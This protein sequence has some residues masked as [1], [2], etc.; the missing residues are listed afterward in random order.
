MSWFRISTGVMAAVAT[1]CATAHAQVMLEWTSN[2]PGSGDAISADESGF[3]YVS[4]GPDLVKLDLAG[5]VVWQRELDP[6]GGGR[7]IS[8][9]HTRD[10]L[11]NIIVTGGSSADSDAFLTLKY[12]SHGNKLWETKT[13]QGIGAFRV[14]TDAI[15]NAYVLGRTPSNLPD[16]VLAKYDPNGAEL[17][18]DVFSPGIINRPHHLAVS[19]N[20]EVAV[21]G[22]SNRVGTANDIMT[23]LYETD[24][25]IR[26]WRSHTSSISGGGLDS[27]NSVAF[28]PN[29]EVYVGGHSENNPSD[30]D[31]TLIKYDAAGNEIWLREY[32]SPSG[33]YDF[34]NRVAVD[35]TGNIF[36]V[37]GSERDIVAIKYDADGTQLWRQQYDDVGG[38]EH[39]WEV[40]VG[41]DDSL[42]ITGEGQ[43]VSITLKYHPDGGL[44]WEGKYSF[45]GGTL[46]RGRALVIDTENGVAVAGAPLAL[47]FLETTLRLTADPSGPVLPGDTLRLTTRGGR[48]GALNMLVVTDV[49]GTP[50]LTRLDVNL[51][52]EHGFHELSGVVPP[53]LGGLNV[54][55]LSLGFANSGDLVASNSETVIMQ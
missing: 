3:L 33:D 52:D 50:L 53:G 27:G 39:V 44:E 14:E 1:F 47:R 26:W 31:F 4:N 10:A 25:T 12:D 41:I 24:G 28:G 51:F 35:S 5:N 18:V 8:H 13:D 49:S 19:P 23:V 42:Y 22:E 34:I 32:Q 21:T 43:D 45:P 36:A 2:T 6:L 15:G 17:W 46:E 37:G 30:L 38:E 9:W 29:G 55:F 48:R 11:G 40:L 7:S 20:G 16:F 54:S